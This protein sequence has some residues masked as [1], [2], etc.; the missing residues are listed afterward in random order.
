MS[1]TTHT[2]R[3]PHVLIT[4]NEQGYVTDASFCDNT[5]APDHIA[6]LLAKSR[7]AHS[8]IAIPAQVANAAPALLAALQDVDLRTAQARIASDIMP[9]SKRASFLLGEL[10]RIQQAARKAVALA[11]GE[12]G[13]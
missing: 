7:G 11:T 9:M 1:A 3:G 4:R 8:M 5:Y 12:E 6:D 2:P 13:R 10:E